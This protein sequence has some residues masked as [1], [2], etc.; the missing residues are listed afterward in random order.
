MPLFDWPTLL[1]SLATWSL[2]PH[3]F[4]LAK[5]QR[6][7]DAY[8]LVLPQL[9]GFL[10]RAFKVASKKAAIVRVLFL[11]GLRTNGLSELQ[12][13][14]LQFVSTEGFTPQV[15]VDLS[16]GGNLTLVVSITLKMLI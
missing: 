2:G 7:V 9:G 13:Y 6:S 15:W 14:Q 12:V 16:L 4:E 5:R 3:D 11:R 10:S 1:F 8:G